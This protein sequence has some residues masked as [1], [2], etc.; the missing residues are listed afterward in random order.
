MSEP[1]HY[2]VVIVQIIHS[3]SPELAHCNLGGGG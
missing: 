3:E 1:Y 2:K